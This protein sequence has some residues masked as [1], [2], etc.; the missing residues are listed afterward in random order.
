MKAEA[1]FTGSDSD[2]A[3]SR[4]SALRPGRA[5]AILLAAAFLSLLAY[6]LVNESDND[7][8]DQALVR[9][10]S[11]PAPDF[12][13]AVLAP[14]A[15]GLPPGPTRA[16]ADRR[17]SLAELRGTPVVLNSWASWCPPCRTEQPDLQRAWSASRG[18]GA[19]FLGLNQQDLTGDARD[20]LAE[21]RVGYPQVRDPSDEVSRSFGA[22]GLPETWFIDARGQVVGHVIGAISPEQLRDGVEAARTST[23]FGTRAGGDRR[24]AGTGG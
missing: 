14:G 17:L 2:R 21:F 7:A 3:D 16:L 23:L 12:E 15:G 8:I 5:F 4:R 11:A 10:A 1:S 20:Y 24:T 19:L 6:G 9:G 13:L 22:T 18:G